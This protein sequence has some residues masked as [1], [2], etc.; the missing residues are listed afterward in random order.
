MSYVDDKNTALLVLAYPLL[1]EGDRTWIDSFR[2]QHDHLFYGIVEPHFTVVFPTFGIGQDDF[3]QEVK[4]KS[5]YIRRFG[6]TIRCAMMNH[7]RLSEYNHIFL[8]PDEGNSNIVHLHDCLYSGIIRKTMRLDIDFFAHIAI[9]SDKDPEKCKALVDEVNARNMEIRGSVTSLDIVSYSD[10]N[11]KNIE[12][13][14][15]A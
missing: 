7:D 11:A 13:I 4:E 9:G 1:T 6:F 12:R 10:R 3:I 5:K 14:D 15:L 2:K 8:S